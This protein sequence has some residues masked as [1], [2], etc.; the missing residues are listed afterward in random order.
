MM[1]SKELQMFGQQFVGLPLGDIQGLPLK[2]PSF[3]FIPHPLLIHIRFYFLLLNVGEMK[4]NC[5]MSGPS[6]WK[7]NPIAVQSENSFGK[8]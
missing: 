4:V 1:I 3:S 7:E 8:H 2:N 5:I 6:R